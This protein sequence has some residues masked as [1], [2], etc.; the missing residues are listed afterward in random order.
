[1]VM[2]FS[3]GFAHTLQVLACGGIA[4]GICTTEIWPLMA[5]RDQIDSGFL[6]AIVQS[7]PFI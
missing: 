4:F 2:F 5:N 1:M 7:D 6:Y 3:A